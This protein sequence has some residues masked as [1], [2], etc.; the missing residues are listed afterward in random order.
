M[1]NIEK[2][3]S[4][5]LVNQPVFTEHIWD[6]NH[7]DPNEKTQFLAQLSSL[8]K[9]IRSN[10]KTDF[11]KALIKYINNTEDN[12]GSIQ[13]IASIDHLLMEAYDDQCCESER[14]VQDALFMIYQIN[15]SHP[16]SKPARRQYDPTITL[17]KAKIEQKWLQHEFNGI[18]L[19]KGIPNDKTF[20]ESLIRVWKNH[21]ASHH[22]LF[23]F[24]EN[25]ATEAQLFFFFKSDSALNLI[26]FDL[27]AYTLIGAQP[28]TRAIISENLWDEIGHGN[29]IFT[30]V[31][32]YKDILS[33]KGIELPQNHYIDLYDIAALTGYNA[34]MLGCVNRCHYYKLLGVMAMTEV[35][36]PP[37]YTKLVK[38]CMRLGLTDRDVHYYLEHITI[39]I[40][41]GEDWL[42]NVINVIADK[43]PASKKE[44]YLGS[45]LRLNTADR[46]YT[47]LLKQ[48]QN[49]TEA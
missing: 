21:P 26:F 31:N 36:D 33:R 7:D 41:H 39:D 11:T 32:L 8:L 34:F 19:E 38:G 28:E 35:L 45:M 25:E 44:F 24:L 42:Y 9:E 29:A 40:K 17:L 16:L 20:A 4:T 43:Y 22:P 14:I 1:F 3:T 46:Y 49:I 15:L 23:D 5:I 12:S 37:Q 18:D 47:H 30:H 27:V 10:E 48:I 2:V 13:L 6:Q